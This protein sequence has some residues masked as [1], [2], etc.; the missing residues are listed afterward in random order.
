MPLISTLKKQIEAA[1][2]LSTDSSSGKSVH[3]RKVLWEPILGPLTAQS[4]LRLLN[5]WCRHLP[6]A[7]FS[8]PAWSCSDARPVAGSC[9]YSSG[10]AWEGQERPGHLPHKHF[11]VT[12]AVGGSSAHPNAYSPV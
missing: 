8:A 3:S 10:L 2:T 7:N 11:P 4:S 6:P 12:E 5:C 1:G 9:S